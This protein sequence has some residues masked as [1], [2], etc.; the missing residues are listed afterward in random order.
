MKL[1]AISS[2]DKAMENHEILE[3][4]KS[5]FDPMAMRLKL[6]KAMVV[7]GHY[8]YS[9]SYP[10]LVYG[11]EIFIELMEFDISPLVYVCSQKQ[12]CALPTYR[13]N[14]D[15]KRHK[16][17]FELI[18]RRMGLNTQGDFVKLRKMKG[19]Y[20]NYE[21]ISLGLFPLIETGWPII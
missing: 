11:L 16:D 5:V 1:T 18:A 13:E 8:S 15:G 14:W 2:P 10:G 19:N 12:R 9:I 7:K 6:E 17:Y 3:K 4:V 21:K 20:L